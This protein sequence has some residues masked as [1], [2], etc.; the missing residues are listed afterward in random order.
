VS[1]AVAVIWAQSAVSP[2]AEVA[3]DFPSSI[4]CRDVTTQEFAAA[5]P[6]LKAVKA[7]LRISARILE[8]S[9]ADIIEFFYVIKTDSTMR[10][11][12]YSPNTT[13]ESAVAEDH[14][15]IT[16]ATENSKTGALDAH[17]AYKPLLLG[18]SHNQTVKKSEAS[19]FN[20]IAAKDIVLASGTIEREH[21]V[22][23]RIRASRTASFEGG[24]E[25]T[26]TATVPR[27]WRGDLCAISCVAKA[28]KRSMMSSSVASIGN[29]ELKI[30]M[31]LSGDVE[32]A[33]LADDLRVAQQTY[34]SLLTKQSAKSDWLH[35]ISTQ[36]ADHLTGKAARRRRELED[37]KKTVA[38]RQ[39]RVERLAR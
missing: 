6:N 22:F 37:A 32:A 27:N 28:A 39:D 20:K 5:H 9:S 14:I 7:K 30:G 17:I 1:L 4:E 23:F 29:A 38:E 11:Q 12:D 16:D 24:K 33:S 35:T 3:F 10:V 2:G 19:H 34:Q 31:Y 36:T 25:F 18:G 13:M 15:E 21:G 26:L 8:G